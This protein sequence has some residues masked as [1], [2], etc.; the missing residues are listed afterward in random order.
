[1]L[2]FVGR[3]PTLRKAGGLRSNWQAEAG[4]LDGGTDAFL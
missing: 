1:M 2:A 4:L 3:R